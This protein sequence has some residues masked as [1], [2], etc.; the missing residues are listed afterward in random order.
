MEFLDKLTEE[1]VQFAVEIAQKAEAMGI[2]P[3]LA[4]ALAYQESRMRPDAVS[5]K[6]AVGLMQVMPGTAEDMGFTPQELHNPSKN[7]EIGLTYLK[8]S[9]EKFDGDPVLAAAGYNAG[10]NHP[11]FSDPDKKSLPE[12]T[13]NYVKSINSYGGFSAS[14]PPSEAPEGAESGPAQVDTPASE[15]DFQAQKARMA[16]DAIGAGA[17][18][19]IGKGLDVSKNIGDTGRAIRQLPGTLTSALGAQGAPQGM[20]PSMPQGMPPSAAGSAPSAPGMARPVAG[21]PAGPVGGPASP[22]QQMGGSAT[23]NYGKAFGL[24]DIEANR[25]TDM[26]K[27][28][29]GANDLINKRTQAL[30]KIQQMGGGYV[31]NPNYGGIM[32]P[33]RSVGSGPRASYVQQPAIPASPDLPGGRPPGLGALPPAQPVSATP[34]APKPPAG[35][36]PLAQM[37]QGLKQGAGA[38]LGSPMVMGALGGISAMESGMEAKKRYSEGDFP[39]AVMAGAGAVGGGM[40]MLPAPQTKGI[41]AMISAASP[42]T[43]YLY[44]KLRGK[45]EVE[46]P[47][48]TAEEMMMARQPAFIYARP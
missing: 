21:G 48:P 17:G 27:N 24:T 45:G 44:D 25:A 13:K 46:P 15:G 7:I 10:I 30:Q 28:P 40:Q 2:D 31:E 4:V 47:E 22:L 5:P 6:G 41:G 42:L 16:A 43:L 32:T 37:G 3:K 36:G 33:E 38:V 20:P 14:K 8:K 1:Q 23:A 9:L 19:A 29:G 11:Y 35:P 39:G 18:A 34:V 12:E 26:T